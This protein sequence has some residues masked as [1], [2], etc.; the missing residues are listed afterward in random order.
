M[1]PVDPLEPVLGTVAR[2]QILKIIRDR[3]ILRLDGTQEVLHD[4][5]GV[6]AKADFDRAIESV[7]VAV[8]AGTLVGLV[9]LHERQ[10]LLSR[11]AFRLEVV[12]IGGRCTS[13]HHEVDAGATTE[14]VG[15]RDDRTSA[16]EPF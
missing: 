5:V 7:D 11:P 2:D 15:T 13:V 1:I 16:T 3:D 6:V 10:Q 12:I 9:L 4:G 14:N 8:V